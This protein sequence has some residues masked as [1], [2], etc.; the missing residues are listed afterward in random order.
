VAPL[1]WNQQEVES[2]G[3]HLSGVGYTQQAAV[4]RRFKEEVSQ[5]RIV[6]LA[7]H[8]LIDDQNP[9]DSR[10]VF[11]Q[12]TADIQEDGYLNAYELYDM[13]IPAEL[14]VLSACET[15]YG[16]L[17]RGEGIMSLARAFAYAGCPSIVMSHWL[18]DD[19]A[20]AQ[21]MD[22]FYRYLSEGLPKDEAL[23]QAKQAYL[24]T[25]SVQKTHPFFWANFVLVGDTAPIASPPASTQRILYAAGVLLLLLGLVGTAYWFRYRL[26]AE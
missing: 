21:L 7:M 13:E 14:V 17:E 9:M 4:E 11:S 26:G 6:H 15:G 24:E 12:D 23:R 3:Q 16:K 8:A 2:I 22:Y 20:S 10:L 25:A 1:R 19:K 18:V 5:Y